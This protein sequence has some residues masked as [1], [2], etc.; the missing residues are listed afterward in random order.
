VNNL[1]EKAVLMG[2]DLSLTGILSEPCGDSDADAKPAFIMLNAGLLHHVGQN[3]MS[4]TLARQ[5]AC[6]GRYA[7]RFDLSGIGDSA[8]RRTELSFQERAISEVQEAMDYLQA[9]KGIDRF[10]LCGL[11]TGADNAFRTAIVEPR[12][13]G[14]IALEGYAY[15][16]AAYTKRKYL[17]KAFNL[18]AWKRRISRYS[19]KGA[20]QEEKGEVIRQ[21]DVSYHWT[22]PPIEQ[23]AVSLQTLIQRKVGMLMVYVGNNNRYNYQGQFADAFGEIDFRGL[24]KESYYEKADH[25][26]SMISD[27]NRLFTEISDW[28]SNFE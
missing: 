1:C 13:C 27:R 25:N 14:V 24:L 21:V 23:M 2:E 26:F 5:L 7:L 28:L 4:V 15:Q 6:Q 17:D 22:L 8:S 16:T 12:V 9:N 10:V 11:C 18:N 19:G 20:Q 3:R